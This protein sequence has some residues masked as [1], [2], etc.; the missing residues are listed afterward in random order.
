MKFTLS[1]VEA[2]HSIST[3]LPW[4]EFLSTLIWNGEFYYPRD[5]SSYNATYFKA[6]SIAEIRGA[7]EKTLALIR[8]G[9]APQDIGLYIHWPFCPSHCDFCA[10]SMA[11]PK[12]Q[13]EI[14]KALGGIFKEID[15]F[16][17]I[18]RGYSLSSFWMG[19][20]TPTFMT[21]EMLKSLMSHVHKSFAFAQGAQIYVEAS[22]ATLT[23]SKLDILLR[24]GLNR[25]TLGIQS[26]DDSLVKAI[27]RQG[28]KKERT[29]EI[30]EKIKSV[31]GLIVDVDLMIGLDGQ[32]REIFVGDVKNIL[33][34]RPHFLHVYGFDDRPQTLWSARGNALS[35]EQRQNQRALLDQA[36]KALRGLGYLTQRDDI[37]EPSL[38]PWEEKQ[39]GGLRK[40]R[41]SVL[42]IGPSAISHAFGAAWY[43]HPLV[44]SVGYGSLPPF[45]WMESDGEEEMRGYALWYF[46]RNQRVSRKAFLKLFGEDILKTR[47]SEIIQSWEALSLVNIDDDFVSLKPMDLPDREVLL[48]GLYSRK[49]ISALASKWAKEL[50]SFCSSFPGDGS[51]REMVRRKND[52]SE[53]RVYRDSRFWGQK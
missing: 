8:A 43:M 44:G 24:Y 39:D 36:D 7:W 25:I 47:L 50:R 29:L 46:S 21:D 27:D 33:E 53:F 40:F 45:L 31:P 6:A 18:F 22:P 35:K 14:E 5:G 30:F 19:G 1:R 48:K 17:D 9:E 28:Q 51:W 41:S 49:V 10:C 26:F 2:G 12:N 11:V 13:S 52:Y 15:S 3:H 42:G 16:S 38:Y 23:D 37:S 4:A 34:F 20:G 32:S